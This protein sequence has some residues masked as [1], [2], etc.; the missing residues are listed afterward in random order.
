M[1][2][3]CEQAL[4]VA[5][6]LVGGANLSHTVER[7]LDGLGDPDLLGA[8]G[9]KEGLERASA[10]KEH[11]KG[12][13]DAPERGQAQLPAEEERPDEDDGG[14]D[15]GA[16]ELAQH[17]AVGVLHGLDVPH[18]GLGEVGQV[19]AAKEREGELPQA[20]GDAD[21]LLAALPV[22]DAVRVVVLLPVAEEEGHGKGGEAKRDGRQARQL[23]A[24]GEVRHEAIHGVE[25]KA[26]AAHGH[27]VGRGRPEDAAPH[28]SIG[29]VGE[30]VLLPEAVEHQASPPSRA[31][32]PASAAASLEIFQLA[33]RS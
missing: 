21:A 31:V 30:Q 14:G 1:V 4:E 18:D 23:G 11:G 33:A 19:A 12:H 28:A 6:L 26:D 13:R 32:A 25:E 22:E 27:E 24:V 5:P 2:D 3:L 10:R 15:D 8:V 29:V 16:P 7:L 17:V 20:L 9:L